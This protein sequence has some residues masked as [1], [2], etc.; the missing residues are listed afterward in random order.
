MRKTQIIMNKSVYLGLSILY[1]SKS[2][3]Y[4]FWYNYLKPKDSE[5]VKFCYMD[6]DSFIAHV[7]ADDICKDIAEDVE[8]RF[9]TPSF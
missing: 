9:Y 7:K 5:N 4:E 1:L 6:T 2:V 8:I 3:M